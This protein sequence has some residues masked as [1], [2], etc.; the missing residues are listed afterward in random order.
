MKCEY[1]ACKTGLEP[2][3]DGLCKEHVPSYL[4]SKSYRRGRRFN[5][6][7]IQEGLKRLG[8]NAPLRKDKLKTMLK[9]QEVQ[10]AL[11]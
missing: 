4:K 3:E 10:E 11:L 1:P 8:D 2:N 9:D 5:L 7:H 6:Q